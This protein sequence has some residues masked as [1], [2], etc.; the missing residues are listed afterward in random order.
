MQENPSPDD[1]YGMATR[2]LQAAGASTDTIQARELADKGIVYIK[3]V[4]DNPNIKPM[5]QFYQ[6]LAFLNIAGN[7]KRP[8]A[9]SI[10]ALDKMIELL[11]E[12]AANKDP[13]N[14]NNQLNLYKNAYAFKQAYYSRLKDAENFEKAVADY[15]AITELINSGAAQ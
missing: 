8:N 6:R 12:D 3:K 14:P 13:K 4:I 1:F 15:N 7:N 2:Y 11:D 10:E 9:E 5:A